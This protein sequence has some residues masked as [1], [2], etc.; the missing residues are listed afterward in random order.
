MVKSQVFRHWGRISG[1]GAVDTGPLGEVEV[2]RTPAGVE[3]ARVDWV[4]GCSHFVQIVLVDVI[5]IV[6]VVTPTLVLVT[7]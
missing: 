2:V 5:R 7:P 4:A 6:L 1:Q 3:D